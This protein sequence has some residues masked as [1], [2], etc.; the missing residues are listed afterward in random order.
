[1]VAGPAVNRRGPN[2]PVSPS[3][4]MG[5]KRTSRGVM[6]CRLMAQSGHPSVVRQCP[7]LGVKRTLQFHGHMSAFDPTRTSTGSA[8]V[9]LSR[10][11]PAVRAAQTWLKWRS[12][13]SALS[14][15]LLYSS[16]CGLGVRACHESVCCSLPCCR[17][18]C[19][20]RTGRPQS[21]ARACRPGLRDALCAGR[22]GLNE[23]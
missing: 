5:V 7:L 21:C 19:G 4:G 8:Y 22:L 9:S 23:M 2:V 1:M 3:P 14:G 16:A 12:H 13:Y 6:R 18:T 15:S 17:R 20:N 11:C 10:Q